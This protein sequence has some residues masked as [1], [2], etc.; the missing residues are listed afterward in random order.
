MLVP[1][2]LGLAK[3]LAGNL[4]LGLHAEG[5]TAS[6]S[7]PLKTSLDVEDCILENV[8][9]K[10]ATYK[11]KTESIKGKIKK[12]LFY[13]AAVILVAFVVTAIIMIFVIP[14]FQDLF[15]SF[16]SDLPVFTQMVVKMSEWMQQWWWALVIGLVGERGRVEPGRGRIPGADLPAGF[17]TLR[18]DADGSDPGCPP[19]ADHAR[20]KRHAG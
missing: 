3:Q 19:G 8:L 5:E 18:H 9:D 7:S 12:A 16:G 4:H 13:P 14:Q 2:V 15:S 17:P 6:G 11:E 10:I 1:E 20:G